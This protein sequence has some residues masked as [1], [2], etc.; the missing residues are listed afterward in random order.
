M[1]ALKKMA[2]HALRAGKYGTDAPPAEADLHWTIW[3][4]EELHPA[5]RLPEGWAD[6]WEVGEAAEDFQRR[7]KA[8]FSRHV[9]EYVARVKKLEGKRSSEDR[10]H[11]EWTARVFA[12]E[13]RTKIARGLKGKDP[14]SRVIRAVLRFAKRTGLVM[15]PSVV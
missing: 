2:G 12:G 7:V 1:A 10:T 9:K 5:F 14:E 4:S 15:P 11:A 6:R 3:P 13:T 8:E